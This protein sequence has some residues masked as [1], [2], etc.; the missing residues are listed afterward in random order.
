MLP[1][2]FPPWQSV[3]YHFNKWRKD[4]TWKKIHKKLF[5][6]TRKRAGRHPDPT[7]GI[8]DNQLKPLKFPASGDTTAEN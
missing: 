4:G 8:I 6:V 5:R 7:A 1:H 3:Y 2:D